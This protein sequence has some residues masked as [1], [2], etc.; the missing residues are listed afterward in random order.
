M[1]QCRKEFIQL[2]YLLKYSM[3]S[4]K[5]TM[6]KMGYLEICYK[7]TP[8]VWH[9]FSEKCKYESF[10]LVTESMSMP[11]TILRP[12]F[13]ECISIAHLIHVYIL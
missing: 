10:F 9:I 5:R 12:L 6:P 13:K 11:R 2:V 8:N 1:G 3:H 7:I 4:K